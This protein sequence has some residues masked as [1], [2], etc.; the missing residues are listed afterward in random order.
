ML[1]LAFALLCGAALVGAALAI[2]YLAA[3]S[4]VPI[5]AA[6]PAVHALL[7]TTGLAVLILALRGGLPRSDRGTAGFGPIAAGLL[8]LALA[9]GVVLAQATWRRRRPAGPLVGAH[10]GL[11][12]AGLVM[13]LALVALR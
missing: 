4:A 5:S 2:G 1:T 10:A 8:G 9:L 6:L 11:A 12:I 13:L 7:G 3:K